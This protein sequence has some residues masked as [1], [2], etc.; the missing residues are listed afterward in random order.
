LQVLDR[1][2]HVESE[3]VAKGREEELLERAVVVERDDGQVTPCHV[4]ERRAEGLEQVL[5]PVPSPPNSFAS[6]SYGD[7]LRGD[8]GLSYGE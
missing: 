3:R 7:Q 4:G 8:G 5:V 2:L 6:S 1:P